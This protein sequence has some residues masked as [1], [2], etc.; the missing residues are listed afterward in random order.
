MPLMMMSNFFAY[1]DGITP[2]HAVSMRFG[3]TPSDLQK[4][5]ASSTS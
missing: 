5:S 4:M 1:R 3:F 2:A